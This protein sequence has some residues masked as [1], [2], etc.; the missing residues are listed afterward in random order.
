MITSEDW[1][2]VSEWYDL[3]DD[4]DDPL[5]K[6]KTMITIKGTMWIRV[7]DNI[8]EM[9]SLPYGFSILTQDYQ[10]L[11]MEDHRSLVRFT[12][13]CQHDDWVE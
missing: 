2:D 10:V 1:D 8:R 9:I 3:P 11:Q 6:K 4:W 5:D 13:V 7:V 12:W